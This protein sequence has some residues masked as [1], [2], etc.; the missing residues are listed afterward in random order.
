MSCAVQ[1]Q[2]QGGPKDVLPPKIVSQYPENGTLFYLENTVTIEFD[3][4]IQSRNLNGMLT[5]SPPIP[6]LDA[7]IKGK[8][9]TIEWLENSYLENTTYRLSLGDA[10]RDFNES[11]PINNLEVVWSTGHYIDSLYLHLMVESEGELNSESLRI[12]LLDAGKDS[13]LQPIFRGALDKDLSYLFTYMPSDTFDI[14]IYEDLNFNGYWD[15]DLESFGFKKNIATRLDTSIEIIPFYNTK[16]EIPDALNKAFTDSI[17]LFIDTSKSENIG[18]LALWLNPIDT[19]TKAWLIHESGFHHY[20]ELNPVRGGDSLRI[21]LGHQLPGKYTFKGFVDE[22]LD[23]NWT[24]ASW[25]NNLPGEY[26]LP[27]Q[28]FELKANWDL[29]QPLNFK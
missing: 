14:L 25:F 2:P 18:N 15:M 6:N 5:L 20:F 1:S 24:P 13:I 11:N 29:E 17:Q 28:T 12:W 27:E 4:Y 16:F 22:N 8:K 19:L 9:L 10:I 21:N 3:E 7:Q 26:I 23:S